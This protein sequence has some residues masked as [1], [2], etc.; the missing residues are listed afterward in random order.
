M[1]STI[2]CILLWIQEKLETKVASDF[3]AVQCIEDYFENNPVCIAGLLQVQ[4][5]FDA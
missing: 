4:Q 1:Y 2:E 3:G 5:P